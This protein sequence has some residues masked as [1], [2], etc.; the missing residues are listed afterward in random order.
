MKRIIYALLIL[1]LALASFGS[2]A[3][4]QVA[5]GSRSEEVKMIQEILKTDPS[6]YPQ[7]LV[8]GY[9]GSLTTEAVKKLQKRCG[10]PESGVLDDTTEKCIYPVGRM[11]RVVNPNGGEN[12]DRNQ[13]YTIK[14]EIISATG[15]PET[16]PFWPKAS[17]DLFRRVKGIVACPPCPAGTT[18]CVCPE[19]EKTSVF[20]RHIATVNLFDNSYSWQI[21]NDIPNGS[22]YVIR[23]S[24]G[25]G[26]TPIWIQEKEA[27]PGVSVPVS[28]T[29]IWPVTPTPSIFWDESDGAFTITG[30]V[31][32]CVC[33]ACPI[34]K[35]D[36]EQVIV[37]LQNMIAELQKAITLLKS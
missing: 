6:I 11:F 1:V 8:T 27:T 32:P 5:I 30:E 28:P 14:W 7:G 18:N 35:P 4:A 2:V 24:T 29:D 3:E 31:Q 21:T 26:I 36:L 22:D 23:I 34:I 25:M 10:L 17:I 37:I 9:Y 16:Q 19:G 20:V 13:I 15:T 33:P 12:L